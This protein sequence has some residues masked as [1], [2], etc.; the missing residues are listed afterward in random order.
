M[1]GSQGRLRRDRG[2]DTDRPSGSGTHQ[3]MAADGGHRPGVA[4]VDALRERPG[5]ISL[6]FEPGQA[7]WDSAF[8]LA[9]RV[10]KT[11]PARAELAPLR[12]R[13]NLLAGAAGAR[14]EADLWPHLRGLTTGLL[15]EPTRPGARPVLCS[16][17]ISI[18]RRRP[19]S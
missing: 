19:R 17:C 5:A 15:G 16:S 3:F 4:A 13:I 9:D 12:A 14:L 18:P 7:Y 2:Y 11:D 1:P 6:A 10:E 8:A